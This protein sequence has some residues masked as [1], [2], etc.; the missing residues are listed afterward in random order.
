MLPRRWDGACIVSPAFDDRW[1]LTSAIRTPA[2]IAPPT[3][4][5]GLRAKHR[6]TLTTRALA[7]V[8]A[9][10]LASAATPVLA[11]EDAASEPPLFG[12]TDVITVGKIGRVHDRLRRASLWARLSQDI[13]GLYG[14]YSRFKTR[15]KKAAGLSWSVP[16]SY[17]QQW[18]EHDGGWSAGQLLATPGLDWEL[19]QHEALGSGSLQVSYTL[20]QYPW[21]QTGAAVGDN[22]ALITPINDFPGDGDSF[23]QLTY[24]HALPGNKLLLTLG[25][26]PFYNFDGNQYLADQQQNFNSYIFAQNGSSTYPLAGLGAYAQVN[27]TSTIQLATG[28]Q[29]AADPSGATLTSKDFAADN[30]AWFTYGQ[31]APKLHGFGPAQYS[32]TYYDVPEVP[33]APASSGWSFNAVQNLN[34]RWAVFGRANGA[35][36]TTTP[37]RASYALGAA[38]NN[39]LGR[40]KTDQIGFAIGY[41]DPADP[42]ANPADARG[43]TIA[44]LY[45]NWTFF[46]GM[47][48]TPDVQY[49]RDPALDA[50]RDD[51]WVLSLRTTVLF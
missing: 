17:M 49:I 45:W 16:V 40:S 7:P 43:E 27:L 42:P 8:L 50:D 20:V 28:F 32:L 41:S 44:E 13:S 9:G 48:L 36:G 26:Y 33:L 11:Q 30:I 35:W 6:R 19:F 24:T 1:A 23:P 14:D 34:D 3:A 21:R 38:F 46:K 2:P 31:W 47:L 4:A 25:Q 12:T 51:A 37:I 22:L 39:P 10:V 29:S 5:M 18:G 15:M